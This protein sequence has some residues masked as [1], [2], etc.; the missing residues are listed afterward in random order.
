V[1]FV[2]QPPP[3]ALVVEINYHDNPWF[4]SVLRAEMEHLRDRDP[5]ATSGSGSAAMCWTAR[6][7]WV[8]EAQTVSNGS[9]N[10]LVPTI[11]EEGSEII[12]TMTPELESDATYQHFA[13][14]Y[15]SQAIGC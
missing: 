4:P 2:A 12:V 5:D 1:P 6:S 7:P 14:A 15:C 11:R 9:W 13:R 8:E 3:N 10:V